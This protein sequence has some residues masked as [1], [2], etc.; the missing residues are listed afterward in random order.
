MPTT[1]PELIDIETLAQLLGDSVRHVRRL[2]A[3]RRVPYLKVGHF[4][5]FDPAEIVEWLDSSR[6]PGRVDR[7]GAGCRGALGRRG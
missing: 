1:V 4:V 2:V 7:P 6:H 3:E 5:R